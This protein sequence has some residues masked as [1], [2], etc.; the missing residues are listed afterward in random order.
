MSFFLFFWGISDFFY[1]VNHLFGIVTRYALVAAAIVYLLL[2]SSPLIFSLSPYYTPMTRSLRIGGALLRIIIRFPLWCLQWCRSRPFDLAGAQY[3]R[4]IHFDRTRLYSIETEERAEKFEPYAMEWLFTGDDLSDNG[5]DKFLE[6][7]A[8]YMSSS[9][10]KKGKL[11]QYLTSDYLLTRIKK[12]FITCATSG[13]LSDEASIARMSSCSKALLRIFQYSRECKEGPSVPN[14]LEE[15]LQLQ[16]SYIQKLM[17]DF[18]TLCGMDDPTIALRASC[19]R[20]LAVQSFLSQLVQPLGR[21]TGLPRFPVPLLP[22]YKFFFPSDNADIIWQLEDGRLPSDGEIQRMWKSLLH[23]GPLANLTNLAQAVR[24][25]EHAPPSTLSFCWKAL[26]ILLTQLGTIHSKEPTRAQIVF[27]DLHKDTRTYVHDGERGF[28]V[29]PLL[30][31]LDTVARGQRLLMVF[32]GHPKYLNRADVVFGKEYLRNGD[33]LEAFAHCLPV[34]ISNNLNA[35]DVCRDFMEKVVCHDDLWT[36]LQVNLWTTQRSDSPTPDKL[37]VFEHCC[38]V[39]DLAFSVLEGSRKVDW[40]APEFGSLAQSFESFIAH[41][42]QDAFMERATSFRVGV[43]KAR[44]CKAL[45]AQFS[46]DIEREGTVSFRSQWDVASL[47]R[48]ICTLGLRDKEDAEF[49]NSYVNGGH[50][51]ADFTVKA[52]EMINITERDGPLLIFCLLGHLVATAVPLD[53]SGLERKDIEK[54]WE[55][56]RKVID[57]KGRPLNRSSDTAWYALGQLRKQVNNLLGK[58]TGK[59][60]DILEDLLQM[61]GDAFSGSEGPGQGEPAEEEVG[62]KTLSSGKSR[63]IGNRPISLASESTAVTR[64][65][66]SDAQTSEGEDSFERASSLSSHRASTDLQ[67]ESPSEKGLDRERK[68][69]GRSDSPQS[70][71]SGSHSPSTPHTPGVG[72]VDRSIGTFPSAFYF[73]YMGDAR[74]RPSTR[75]TG[76]GTNATRP[77]LVNRASTGALFTS[78]MYGSFD[79]SDGGRSGTAPTSEEE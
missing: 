63:G 10:T 67:P 49:W 78:R 73:P 37:R 32:S 13:E 61:I 21:T 16:R 43:I 51:G 71:D 8:G 25:G 72:I 65:L 20:A 48:L 68:T 35:P 5:M 31:I 52:L 7:L 46:N 2:S 70:Y 59:D 39:I 57:E 36:S 11:D 44:F 26:D 69:H 38:T 60:R 34:F 56:Q 22:I 1:T 3:Y 40:R 14:K 64:G 58:I 4:G 42:F 28:R 53:Q 12:H 76:S 30:D 19:I 50:I 74:Q 62:P 23:D 66:S 9:H 18:Q 77:G 75:Q 41:C 29:T 24:N 27:D 6:S 33:L 55:L 54:V 47:A 17:D 79:L 15:E 45:L